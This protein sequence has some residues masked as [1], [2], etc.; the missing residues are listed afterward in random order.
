MPAPAPA[1][2]P[3]KI[4]RALYESVMAPTYAPMS[5]MPERG[6][7][8]RL[9]DADG[10][11]Y[12]DF[13]AGIAVSALGHAHPELR[14]VLAEQAGKL[15]HV[16]NLLVNAP[17]I[18]LARRLCDMTFAERVFFA[19]SGAEANE[20]ALK[21]ARRH[22]QRRFGADKHRIIAFDNA[23]HG[24]TF[25]RVGGAGKKKH[26][27]SWVPNRGGTSRVPLKAARACE[28]AGDDGTCGVCRELIQGEGGVPPAHRVC[29]RA[30]RDACDRH[31]ALLIFDEVQTG[32][33]RCGALYLHQKLGVTPDIMTTAKGL[34]GGLP[35][36]AMLSSAEVA[37]SFEV[38]AHGS[39]FG[40]NPVAC[41]VANRVLEIVGAPEMLEAVRGKGEMLQSGLAAI[42]RRFGAF[43]EIR[44]EGLLLG[45]AL[46]PDWR[47]R[48]R[49][50]VAACVR[51]GLLA[52]VA[53]PDV[54]RLAPP[55]I[56]GD[57]ELQE[58]LKK[59][60]AAIGELARAHE[61]ESAAAKTA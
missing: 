1:K 28:P 37:A 2:P 20:A 4:E 48:A 7:G 15:W 49:D 9:W 17:A 53:G 42:G 13:A 27:H 35:I 41:A 59:L 3:R 55:L 16:S 60:E 24:R 43:A 14:R 22:A 32:V 31:N 57:A 8:A 21:L 46:A 47:G 33:G 6:E 36:G 26:R 12:L 50:I 10:N 56:I 45:C 58:G 51:H 34:G 52:L 38:G 54:L 5:I 29:V 44:G 39:T 40:G 11:V 25:S 23:F 30:A 61:S 18:E 19:N